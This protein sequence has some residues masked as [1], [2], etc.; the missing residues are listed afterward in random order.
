VGTLRIQ[1]FPDTE[2]PRERLERQGPQSLSNAELLAILL[3]TGRRGANVVEVAAELLHEHGSLSALTRLSPAQIRRVKGIGRAKSVELVAAFQLG[4]RLALEKLDRNK[5]EG[6]EC[7]YRLMAPQMQ[8]LQKESLRAILLDTRH[9]VIKIEQISLGSINESIAH[10]REIF[11][12]ALV[13][14]A[15]GI[16]VVHNHPSGDPAPS[17][18]DLRLTRRLAEAGSLLQ[19]P[20]LDHVIVGLPHP[21]R[22]SYYSFKEAGVL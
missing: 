6:P 13:H 18:A 15:Y 1:D 19:V 7:V 22:A 16:I 4:E 14:S 3:R 20:L 2:K 10:P 17:E 9:H 12:P 5:I 8:P 21:S 11:Q